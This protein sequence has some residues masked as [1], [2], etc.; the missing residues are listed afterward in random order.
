MV[1]RFDEVERTELMETPA[2][3]RVVWRSELEE[4]QT[5]VKGLL[6]WTGEKFETS[7]CRA[8]IYGNK[9]QLLALFDLLA[10][11]F[12]HVDFDV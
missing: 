11:Q 7:G 8:A 9:S 1:R 5:P 4:T 2:G 12:A 10:P 6:L 3:R